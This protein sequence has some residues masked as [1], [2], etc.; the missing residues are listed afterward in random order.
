MIG[1]T[2]SWV[3]FAYRVAFAVCLLAVAGVAAAQESLLTLEGR[4]V[5]GSVGAGAGS[6]VVYKLSDTEFFISEPADAE[7]MYVV[8]LP[9]GR[10]CVPVAVITAQGTRLALEGMPAISVRTGVRQTISLSG[11][12][13]GPKRSVGSFPGSDRLFL[14]FVE[15]SVVVESQRIEAQFEM[16]DFDSSDV[17]QSRFVGAIQL[18]AIPSVEF[19]IRAGFVGVDNSGGSAD[20]SGIADL[21]LWAKLQLGPTSVLRGA[22]LSV[23]ALVTLPTGDNDPG[24]GFDASRV[25]LFGAARFNVGPALMSAHAGV[26]L[27]ED[28][29]IFGFELDGQIAPAAGVAVIWGLGDN[30]VLV[31]EASFEGERFDGGDADT[32]VLAGVNWQALPY[33]TA[34]LAIAAGLSDAAPDTQL[35]LGYDFEF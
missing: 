10:E 19:G 22:D 23:G 12:A 33:G 1:G 6:R 7:G 34:R 5:N 3:R 21:D 24:I 2:W 29:E 25:K 27:N 8:S 26:R 20:Q 28:G 30:L 16:A 9:A 31:G 4:I 35:I 13:L 14:S 18:E 32:R 15:D 11:S 17:L